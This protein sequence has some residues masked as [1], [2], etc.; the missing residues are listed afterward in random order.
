MTSQE[1]RR[2]RPDHESVCISQYRVDASCAV[3]SSVPLPDHDGSSWLAEVIARHAWWRGRS[4]P[5]NA[6]PQSHRVPGVSSVRAPKNGQTQRAV[7]RRTMLP[8]LLR[9]HVCVGVHDPSVCAKQIVL[10]SS[11]ACCS[12]VRGTEERR[13]GCRACV[14]LQ[15]TEWSSVGAPQEWPAALLRAPNGM[16]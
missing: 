2:R 12:V 3:R 6:C 7:C 10:S 16:N 1:P 8:L 9:M 4:E 14:S 5:M 15:P 11:C 13:N